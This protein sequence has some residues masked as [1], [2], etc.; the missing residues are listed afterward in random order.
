MTEA[1]KEALIISLCFITGKEEWWFANKT[2][3][4]L[5]HLYDRL[6]AIYE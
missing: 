4:E 6:T 2:A 3:E 1:D 5:V